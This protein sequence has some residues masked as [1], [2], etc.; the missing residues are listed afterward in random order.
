M[1][2][3]LTKGISRIIY[4]KWLI[5]LQL[6]KC[7]REGG[8]KW[9]IITPHLTFSYSQTTRTIILLSTSQLFYQ[10]LK[11]EIIWISIQT[12]PQW[13]L[14]N[15]KSV[16]KYPLLNKQQPLSKRTLIRWTISMCHTKGRAK[17]LIWAWKQ[18]IQTWTMI[19]LMCWAM[20]KI[21]LCNLKYLKLRYL[22]IKQVP[23][24]SL[25]RL[26][27]YSHKIRQ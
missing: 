3:Y 5:P 4:K 18:S 14:W 2:N 15:S 1:N 7:K 13:C 12:T 19:L 16:S 24:V 10:T 27:K 20:V 6:W 8:A 26:I 25:Q 23:V 9:L 11:V 21:W 17:S 22:S